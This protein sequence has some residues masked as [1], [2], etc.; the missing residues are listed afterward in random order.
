MKIYFVD[1][2][3]DQRETYSLMLQECFP[4]D[5]NSPKV[6]GI[7]PKATPGEMSFLLEDPEVVAIVLD[8]QLKDSGVAQYFG[9]ELA[10]YLRGLNKKLPIYILTSFVQ[11][12]E[13][14][15]GEMEVEDILSK[16]ELSSRVDIVGARI[17]RRIDSYIE[18][19]GKRDTRFELLLRKSFKESLSDDESNELA[20][21]GF[22]RESPYEVNE[23]ISDKTL[24]KLSII[25]KQ[26][27][28]I[29]A[30]IGKKQ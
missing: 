3:E 24:E 16:Q 28:I 20:E 13:L 17:L 19:T 4:K 30:E 15:E 14:L 21:L 10:S 7:E 12:E 6:Y 18:V 8:E 22:L 26:I 23:I 2:D 27:S 1:E 9:I 25:E 29:E 11:S 5:E